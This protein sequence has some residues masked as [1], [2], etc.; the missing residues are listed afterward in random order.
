MGAGQSRG[1]NNSETYPAA[2]K[3]NQRFA[4]L[5]PGVVIDDPEARRQGVRQERRYLKVEVLWNNGKPVLRYDRQ[6]VKGGNPSGIE[7]FPAP[8]VSGRLH[9]QPFRGTPVQDHV[10]A[11]ADA[12][13]P[14]AYFLNYTATLVAE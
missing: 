2:A 9:L 6:L 3:D 4:Y 8:A 7:A 14:G 11:G 10:I 5:D 12:G 1:Q 13:Y